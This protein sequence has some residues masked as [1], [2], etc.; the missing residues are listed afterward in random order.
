MGDSYM[1]LLLAA[2]TKIRFLREPRRSR[3]AAAEDRAECFSWMAH[4]RVRRGLDHQSSG[5]ER[6]IDAQFSC[7]IHYPQQ[8]SLAGFQLC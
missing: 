3:S 4:I 7:E 6:K 8:H 2:A 1:T 5:R